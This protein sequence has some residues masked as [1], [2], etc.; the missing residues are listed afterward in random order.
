M[1]QFANLDSRFTLVAVVLLIFVRETPAQNI[2]LKTGQTIET[3]AIRRN[4]GMVLGKIQAGGGG[5]EIGYPAS[6]IARIGFPEPPQLKSAARF[7]SQGEPAKA[8]AEIGPV[9]KY[10][11]AFR[12]IAGNWWAQAALLEVAALSG[13]QLDR[14]AEALGEEIRK[15]ATDPETARA[16]QLQLVP[17]FVR[18]EEFDQAL[19]L[20]DNVIKESAR[21]EVL[22]EAW[23]RKGDAFLA[24]RQ[25][26]S[27]LLAYLH[28]PV[29][30]PEEKLWMPSALLGS[31]RAFRG[32]NDLERA[33]KSLADLTAEFP[34]SAQ[35]QIA[36]VELK[37]LRK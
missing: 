29:L 25:W 9:V 13:M 15:N 34:K 12:D 37:K 32:L 30:Y 2:I 4:A 7:L 1:R 14:Q 3:K 36:Q 16:A 11:G 10:Y 31:G 18:N 22:A 19:Q 5:G 21:P 6:A 27:A 33:K 24:Q 20:C 26:D 17:G 35:A 8:L 23:V 28:I